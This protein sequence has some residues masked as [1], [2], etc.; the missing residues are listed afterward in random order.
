MDGEGLILD[1]TAADADFDRDFLEKLGHPVLV[2]HA[3]RWA[4]FVRSSR[5]DARW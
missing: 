1:A 3:P 5:M 2:C 4:T